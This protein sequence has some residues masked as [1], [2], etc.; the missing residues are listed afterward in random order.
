ML[1]EAMQAALVARQY[2]TGTT[3]GDVA[4]AALRAP[5]DL[6]QPVTGTDLL[7]DGFATRTAVGYPQAV[8]L[9]RA[10]VTAL[11]TDD[12]PLPAGIPATILGWF[13]ADDLWDDDG[14]RDMLM[15]AEAV[16]RRHGALGALRI[17]LAGLTT[18]EVW[19]GRPA[20]AEASYLQ[21]AGISASMGLPA[22]AT[23][24]VLLEL[25]A[26]QGREEESRALAEMTAQWGQQR[27]AAVLEV[28]AQMGLTVLELGLGRYAEA[29]GQG[30]RI[31]SDDPP[32]FG[33]RILPEIAEAGARSGDHDAAH[34]ALSRLA[35]RATASGTP[36]ALGM[37]ARSRALLAADAEAETFYRAAIA[38]LTGTSV[39]TELARAYLLYGE[40][41]RRQRRRRDARSQLLTAYGMFDAMGAAAFAHRTRAELLAMGDSPHQP[42]ER[43][44]PDLT[45]QEAQV[46]R[47]AAA[48]A[49]N[50]EIATHLFVT[51]STVEYH[52]SKVFRKLSITSRRQLATTLARS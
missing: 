21:A 24:G 36:W 28:F 51:T 19:A 10:A 2:T 40:W 20:E 43:A 15:R 41:L 25:R 11:F 13:A 33:N 44:G 17:T 6:G 48:G 22:P 31:Y 34:A 27:G 38:H 37:L 32:G 30:M 45:P 35:E 52:L 3:P 7:L 18:G 47:L 14:R 1:F 5:Q 8:P 46:S 29:L 50:A 4:D 12:Q 23:M 42:T 26:W 9:L 16:Q 49:T 39:R